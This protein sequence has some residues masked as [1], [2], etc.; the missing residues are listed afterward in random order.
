MNVRQE[1][2]EA[3][4]ALQA[5]QEA[6]L[7]YMLWEH[8]PTAEELQA[9]RDSRR[10]LEAAEEDHRKKMAFEANHAGDF[11]GIRNFDRDGN[12]LS[13]DKYDEHHPVGEQGRP[14]GREQ[15]A[16]AGSG[17]GGQADQFPSDRDVW[18]SR[19]PS[20]VSHDRDGPGDGREHGTG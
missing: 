4:D 15:P 17:G 6:E 10:V 12:I 14:A 5:A 3:E 7:Q 11:A 8:E 9:E 16:A 2:L 1:M 13:A 19:G 18:D 20:V